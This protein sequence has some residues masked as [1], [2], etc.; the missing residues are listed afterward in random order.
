MFELEGLKC[1]KIKPLRSRKF[2]IALQSEDIESESNQ[3]V[4]LV[5]IMVSGS[6]PKNFNR[7][8]KFQQNKIVFFSKLVSIQTL[9]IAFSIS[10]RYTHSTWADAV[11][12]N[13]SQIV[14]ARYLS[15]TKNW[16]TTFDSKS[17]EQKSVFL[18]LY[19]SVCFFLLIGSCNQCFSITF[20]VQEKEEMFHKK[21]FNDS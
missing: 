2:S 18:S 5:R 14:S 8:K 7:N 19:A 9:A 21:S 12:W 11:F 10:E 1:L 16:L 15:G 3:V 6:N 20:F 17:S 4:K 13:K